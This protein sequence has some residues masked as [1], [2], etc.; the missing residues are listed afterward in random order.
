MTGTRSLSSLVVAIA[1]LLSTSSVQAAPLAGSEG[2]LG[3]G[4]QLATPR[5]F[6]ELPPSV[7]AASNSVKPYETL[8]A[9]NARP[10]VM[11]YKPGQPIPPG[12]SL[13]SRPDNQL[14]VGIVILG[15]TYASSALA[16]DSTTEA[17]GSSES[18]HQVS[19]SQRWLYVPVIGPWIAL[20]TAKDHDCRNS[21]Y[22]SSHFYNQCEDANGNLGAW[23]TFLV[24]D[25]ILQAVGAALAFHALMWP[26]RQ[27]VLT[28][29]V[30]VQV[31]PVPMGRAGEGIAVAGG[32]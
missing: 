27:L 16:A 24:T 10:T 3:L 1:G 7:P 30:Q 18:F 19:F 29:S 5:L 11:D 2:R 6:A 21:Y 17:S 22:L 25:G 8:S 14:E 31:L 20:A 28:D 12:Y 23:Q 15:I 9:P 32:F 26:R 13:V 4:L